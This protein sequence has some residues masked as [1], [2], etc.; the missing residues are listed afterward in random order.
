[1][2]SILPGLLGPRAHP[3]VRAKESFTGQ[4]FRIEIL[5]ANCNL[6]FF[7]QRRYE[8]NETTSI[9]LHDIVSTALLLHEVSDKKS[10]NSK[11][12]F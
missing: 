11:Q 3:K 9:I 12:S 8:E 2:L 6:F 7:V 5:S 4:W 10:R 1:M